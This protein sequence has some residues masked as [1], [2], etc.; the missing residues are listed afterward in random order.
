MIVIPQWPAGTVALLATTGPDGA[1]RPIPVSTALRASDTR[2]L[3]ALGRRR[4]ALQAVRDRP[5]CALALLAAGNVAVTLHG[6]GSVVAEGPAGAEGI[7]VVALDVHDVQD[8]TTDRFVIA[9]GVQWSWIDE[10]ARARDAAV[11]AVL[12]SFAEA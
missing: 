9:D 12:Q 6:R 1:P 7:A 11:R 10:D 4:T 2:V 3:L 8:H 5:A